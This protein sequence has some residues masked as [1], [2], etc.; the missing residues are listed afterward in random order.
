MQYEVKW[1]N[2][3]SD[4]FDV[5]CG[6]KQGG[7][8]SPDFFGIYINDLIIILRKTGIGCHIDRKFIACILFADDLSLLAPTRQSLQRMLKIC[9]DYCSR[10]CLQFNV[11]KTQIMIFGKM[12]NVSHLLADISFQGVNIGF[13]KKC[14]YLGFHVMSGFNFNISIQKDVCGFYAIQYQTA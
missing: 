9:A 12:S 13:V 2:V 3:K 14:K 7:I 10:F 5:L 1:C 11:K 8:L 6:S 4:Y